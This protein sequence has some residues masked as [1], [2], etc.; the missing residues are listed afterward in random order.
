MKVASLPSGPGPLIVKTRVLASFTDHRRLHL[1]DLAARIRS[2]ERA[3]H[4]LARRVVGR[5]RQA[6]AGRHRVD[7]G[8]HV[9]L[10]VGVPAAHAVPDERLAH[11]VALEVGDQPQAAH[12]GVGLGS[13]G[14]H[15]LRDAGHERLH[16]RVPGAD[17]SLQHLDLRARLRRG[18][19]ARR[20]ARGL[21]LG[22]R[23]RAREGQT[24]CGALHSHTVLLRKD[25]GVTCEAA[26]SRSAGPRAAAARTCGSARR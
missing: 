16:G 25:E 8:A 21:V 13:L 11:H 18:R 26:R 7:P 6:E 15:R 22:E 24:E 12:E 9:L 2:L 3:G 4:R 23:Q 10:L 19:H 14:H 17:V 20:R 1:R 5:F